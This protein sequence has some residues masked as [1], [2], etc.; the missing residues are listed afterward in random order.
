MTRNIPTCTAFLLAVIVSQARCLAQNADILSPIEAQAAGGKDDPKQKDKDK[1][2]PEKDKKLTDPAQTD[3][4]SRLLVP[5]G[6]APSGYNPHML[7]DLGIAKYG[8]RLQTFTGS[9]TTTFVPITVGTQT[10]TP[11]PTTTNVTGSRVVLVPVANQGA[12]KA[13]ENASPRPQDRVFAFYNFYGDIRGPAG[14]YNAPSTTV[15][16]GTS[17]L[18]NTSTTTT[19]PGAPFV[20][21]HRETF[22]FEK[23]FLDGNAS[24]EFRLPVSQQGDGGVNGFGYSNVGDLTII[25]KYAVINDLVS[26]NVLSGGLSITAPTGPRFDTTDGPI[27]STLLQP[28]LGYIYNRDRFF[29]HA[30]HSIVVPTDSR[31]VTLLFND[32]GVSAWLYISDNPGRLLSFVV[33]TFEAHITTPLNHRGGFDG[34][35]PIVVPDVVVLTGG[36]HLGLFRRATLTFGAGVPVTGPSPYSIEAY[37]QFNV[38]Y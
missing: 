5:R 2:P 14:A 25:T 17:G 37:T 16:T 24:I 34:T 18:F 26:G 30:F 29:L 4:F 32:V 21:L 10:A 6:E 20:N 7:G 31:D 33:P 12:F 9:A 15:T 13:A 35:N 1:K 19:I 28:W 27:R 38:R 8:R 22:G 36:V 3:V 11:S 23:T